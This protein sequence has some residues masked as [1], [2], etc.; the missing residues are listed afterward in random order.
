MAKYSLEVIEHF[1]SNI[2]SLGDALYFMKDKLKESKKHI[3]KMEKKKLKKSK[4]RLL[5][6]METAGL[7]GE[8][9]ISV[10]QVSKDGTSRTGVVGVDEWL[11]PKE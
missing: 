11:K 1:L 2:D 4:G 6:D 7:N 5:V 10:T 8:S 9:V 3:K